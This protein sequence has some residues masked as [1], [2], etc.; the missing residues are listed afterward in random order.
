MTR[1]L[2]NK[3]RSLAVSLL[4]AAVLI[5]FASVLIADGGRFRTSPHGSS[6]NGVLRTGDYPRGSCAQCHTPHDLASA[7]PYALFCENSNDLCMTA[8]QGGCHADQPT[9]AGAGY[10]A[11]ESDRMPQGS[12]DPGYFE[13][14]NGG[15][16][17]PGLANLVRWPGQ[18]VWEDVV[19]SAHK[20]DPDMPLKDAYGNGSCLNCHDVHGG[21]SLHDMLDT[22]YSGI[23]SAVL[24]PV[25]TNLELC[26]SCHSRN[27]PV[28]M[29]DSSKYIADY[30]DR[31]LNPGGSS[32]HG[33]A[34]GDGYVSAGAR[35][36][37][38]DCHNPH[39]SQGYG[40]LGANG[41]LLS[42]QRPGWYALTDI[43]NDSVQVRRFCFGCHISSDG[44]GGG[45]IEGLT[46]SPL[47]IHPAPHTFDHPKHCY[48]CHGR[49]YSSST[50]HN[51]HNPS[52]GSGGVQ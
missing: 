14:N 22:T 28:G 18:Q 12:P 40:K 20:T 2:T 31:T 26:L 47:S 6:Q 5:A 4:C 16:R 49:D 43:K 23:T 30:Y 11:Q 27:A 46:L 45:Q 52:P 21:A 9:G 13:Y 36:P 3:R 38:Y 15:I 29:D 25:A 41:Y 44:Q 42:D 51:V 33:V 34:H 17:L 37:C 24:D 35:L 48:D 32:G 19:S 10:P 50:S 8:S 7:F 39:G 1:M